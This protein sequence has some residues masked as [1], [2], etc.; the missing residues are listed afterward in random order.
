MFSPKSKSLSL[1]SASFNI[2]SSASSKEYLAFLVFFRHF[3][4]FFLA[5]NEVLKKVKVCRRPTTIFDS[6]TDITMTH[7]QHL[8]FAF[9]IPSP[10]NLHLYIVI[11]S[12]ECGA[13][14]S[15]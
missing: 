11:A 2:I 5:V 6:F 1:L 12:I 3:H 8:V 9:H 10:G 4:T 15:F 13:I 7:N 14:S